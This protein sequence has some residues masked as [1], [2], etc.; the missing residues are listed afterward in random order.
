MSDDDLLVRI[1][2]TEKQYLAALARMESQSV[3]S[4]K[5]AET[6]WKKSNASFVR[7]AERANRSAGSFANGGLRQMGMQLSQVAQ[8]G[9]VTGDY[10]RA[11]TVQAADI[12]LAF[13]KMGIAIGAAISV[14]GPM[15]IEMMKTHEGAES[16]KE[17]IKAL[18]EAMQRLNEARNNS[19]RGSADL[20][21]EYGTM[22]AAARELF[23]IEQQIAQMRSADALNTATRSIAGELGVGG[24]LDFGPDQ[25]RKYEETAQALMDERAKLESL[26][27]QSGGNVMDAVPVS[28]LEA[29][30][31]RIATI[32][33]NLSDLRQV[34]RNFDD[35]ADMLGIT[36][37]EAREVAARFAEIGQA[38]G[39]RA[40]AE[41][42]NDLWQYIAKASDN[43]SDATAEGEALHLQ[44]KEVVLASMQQATIDVVSNIAAGANEAARMADEIQRAVNGMIALSAQGI[45]SLRESEIRL[46]HAGD[47][48]ATAGAL[49]KEKFGDVSGFDPILRGAMEQKRDQYVSDAMA[50]ERNRQALIEAQKAASSSGKSKRSGGSKSKLTETQKA[51]ADAIKQVERYVEQTRTAVEQYNHEL[52]QLAALKPFF[53]ATGNAEAYARAV[54][55]IEEEFRNVQFEKVNNAI[56]SISDA[57]ADAIVNGEDMGDALRNVFKR[58]AADLIASGISNMLKNVFSGLLGGGGAGGGILSSIFA[59]FFDSGGY[60]PSGKVGM[61]GEKGPELV[62]GPAHVISRKD[63]AAMMRGGG[64]VSMGVSVTVNA[65]SNEPPAIGEEVAQAVRRA[66]EQIVDHKLHKAVRK[67]GLI[68]AKYGG[69]R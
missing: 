37:D 48:V 24:S 39:A 18:S 22:A 15:A 62:H 21:T 17:S 29:A 32:N 51:E 7:G 53:E 69:A 10:L 19:G 1:G 8:Q 65:Q 58:I 26:F 28:Q 2:L 49:A 66:A 57:M 36:E 11:M 13:G 25:I 47:P 33:S 38:D 43:L 42:A 41:A 59:G 14:L 45:S 16:A 46:Q 23:E 68:D 67:G 5:K 61:A 4:A 9:A 35:L 44:L 20:A 34:T 40:Q 50:T 55:E 30:A 60:I 54:Q 52:E 27:A 6:E 31:D 12:G 56:D 3:R 63:T 64:S